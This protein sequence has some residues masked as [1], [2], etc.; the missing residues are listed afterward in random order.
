M[1]KF[2]N[3]IEV[4]LAI[5]VVGLGMTAIMGLFPVGF[6]ASRN[7]I[8]DNYSA[9]AAEQFMAY[10]ARKCNDPTVIA[11]KTAWDS[12]ISWDQLGT[13]NNFADDVDGSISI[14]IPTA[15]DEDSNFSLTAV[16]GNIYPHLTNTQLYWIKSGSSTVTD[17]YAAVRIWRS[18]ITGLWLFDQNADIPYTIATRLNVEISWPVD[19]PYAS[20]DKKYYCIELF[21]QR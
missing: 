4:T 15:A 17:F 13:P 2:F 12:L 19:K 8:G 7:A 16:E 21:R 11:T 9:N 1:K 20:R 10:I 5:A 18:Q 6:Q 3:M 14:T